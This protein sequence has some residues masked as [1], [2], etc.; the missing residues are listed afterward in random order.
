MNY[1]KFS[2]ATQEGVLCASGRV[3]RADAKDFLDNFLSE[4]VLSIA[5]ENDNNSGSAF[6]NVCSQKR[7][8]IEA[9]LCGIERGNRTTFAQYNRHSST[10][11]IPKVELKPTHRKRRQREQYTENY[12]KINPLAY[13]DWFGKQPNKNY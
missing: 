7:E 11:L 2:T 4:W 1:Y 3:S 10:K 6:H 9:G 8:R 12:G 13:V 5:F